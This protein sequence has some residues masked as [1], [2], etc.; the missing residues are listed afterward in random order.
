MSGD[1]KAIASRAL[2][3]LEGPKRYIWSAQRH[4]GMNKKRTSAGLKSLEF[5]V[6]LRVLDLE[7]AKVID[8]QGIKNDVGTEAYFTRNFPHLM[9]GEEH[10]F[11][12]GILRIC[13]DSTLSTLNQVSRHRRSSVVPLNMLMYQISLS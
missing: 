1:L 7:L 6:A 4:L 8:V 5:L 9:Q 11:F 10:I 12:D 13:A 3:A 2:D